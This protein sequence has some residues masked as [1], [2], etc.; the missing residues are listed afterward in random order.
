M[1]RSRDPLHSRP[2]PLLVLSTL[3][4]LAVAVTLPYTAASAWLGFR[5]VPI[6]MLGALAAI[7]AVYLSCAFAVRR[8]FFAGVA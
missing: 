7:T 5:P 4:M 2:H 8:W 1:I 3:G 6:P